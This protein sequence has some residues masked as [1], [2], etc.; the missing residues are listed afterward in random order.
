MQIVI[1]NI[2]SYPTEDWFEC[3]YLIKW[4]K[5]ILEITMLGGLDSQEHTGRQFPV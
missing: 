5:P 2:A 3:H 4:L 1:I